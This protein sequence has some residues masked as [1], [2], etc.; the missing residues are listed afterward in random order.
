MIFAYGSNMNINR[1]RER[2]PSATKFA[3]A[4]ITGYRLE[5][6]KISRKDGSAKAN[7]LQTG[8]DVNIV[9]GVLFVINNNEKPAL[10]RLEGLGYGYEE[11]TLTFVDAVGNSHNAKV[12]I[13]YEAKY[14]NNELWPYDWYREFI[15]SGAIQAQ[16]PQEYIDWLKT[17]PSTV[18]YD[19]ARRR[20]NFAIINAQQ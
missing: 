20:E 7:I 6:N 17:I 5:C 14:L 15:L 19:V 18:D 11:R 12:Y 8:N 1:L 13:A 4:Y 9:W 2:V 16:F 3:N 10:D